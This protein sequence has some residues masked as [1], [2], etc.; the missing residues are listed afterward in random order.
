MAISI[1]TRASFG[2]LPIEARGRCKDGTEPKQQGVAWKKLLFEA[3]I[4]IEK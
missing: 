3:I 2:A 4:E 1:A